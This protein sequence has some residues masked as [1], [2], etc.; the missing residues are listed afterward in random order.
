MAPSWAVG[1]LL[2]QF[3]SEAASIYSKE[4]LAAPRVKPSSEPSHG[5][6]WEE[7]EEPVWEYLDNKN[8]VGIFGVEDST[9]LWRSGAGSLVVGS[10]WELLGKETNPRFGIRHSGMWE[11]GRDW[12]S[13]G[14]WYSESL[15]SR[16]RKM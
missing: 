3:P 13:L 8:R 14:E 4:W 1:L 5:T 9:L 12:D 11:L 15:N 2:R 6:W 7:P 16:K 10:V